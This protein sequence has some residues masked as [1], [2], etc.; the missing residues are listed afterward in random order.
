MLWKDFPPE[1]ATWEEESGLH[2]DYIDEYEAGLAA[3]EEL[4]DDESDGEEG[5]TD[6][7]GGGGDVNEACTRCERTVVVRFWVLVYGLRYPIRSLL[8]TRRETHQFP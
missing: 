8:C 2:D 1:I 5:E 4:E 7:D 6:A 3:E